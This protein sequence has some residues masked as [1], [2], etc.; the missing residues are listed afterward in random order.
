MMA[1]RYVTAMAV[2]LSALAAMSLAEAADIPLDKR[3]SAYDGMSRE[4]RAMQDDDTS[5]PA[6]LWVLDG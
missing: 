2:A 6:T 1:G 3:Q 5:N 4:T